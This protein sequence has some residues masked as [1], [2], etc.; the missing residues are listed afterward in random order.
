MLYLCTLK[1]IKIKRMTQKILIS[2]LTALSIMTSV[3][4]YADD[5]TYSKVGPI[6]YAVPFLTIAPDARSGAMGD[7]GVAL[8]P[9]AYGVHYNV[10]KAAMSEDEGGLAVNY[11]PWMSDIVPD[12]GLMYFSGFYKFGKN[13]EQAVSGSLR[14][15]NLGTINYRDDQNVHQGDGKPY[16]LAFDLGYSRKLSDNLSLGAGIRY[17]NSNIAA[18]VKGLPGGSGYKPANAF[19]ADLGIFYT[20]TNMQSEEQGS[21]FN[22]GAALRNLGSRVT[23]SNVHRDFLPA[24]LAVG[25]AYTYIIDKHNK[26]TASID[27][28]KLLVPAA[29][30]EISGVDTYYVAPRDMSVVSGALESFVKAPGMYGTTIGI[31]G[32]YWYQDQFALRAGYFH[33]GKQLGNRQYFAVG[34]GARY[35][36]FGIDASYLVPSGSGI[37]RNPLSNTL[38]FSLIFN[39]NNKKY[40][41]EKEEA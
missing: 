9:D 18:G 11:S 30:R 34:V 24:Q 38:R 7:V 23:Y 13:K 6:S 14:Y 28:V 21:T 5:P 32:E 1:K 37:A 22:F 25:A 35:S 26:F 31:G 20:K 17:I 40:F 29:K 33:E 2:G 19:A 8:A 10:S 41:T 12:V 39:F 15:F 36:M 27:L 3:A 4:G 16:E